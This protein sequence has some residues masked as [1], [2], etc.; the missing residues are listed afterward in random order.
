[1]TDIR[2]TQVYQTSTQQGPGDL[3][4]TQMYAFALGIAPSPD[5][6]E[7]QFYGSALANIPDSDMRETQAYFTVTMEGVN[8]LRETLPYFYVLAGLGTFPECAF[9]SYFPS[10]QSLN[11]L[12]APINPG[13]EAHTSTFGPQGGIL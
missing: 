4:E 1:M 7:T 12:A 11:A 3:R 6:R 8:E 5:E 10:G 9:L 2:A 13:P